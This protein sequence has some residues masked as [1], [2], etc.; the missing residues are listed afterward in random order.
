MEDSNTKAGQG[1]KAEPFSTNP[2]AQAH[3]QLAACPHIKSLRTW[4]CFVLQCSLGRRKSCATHWLVAVG[5]TSLL[6]FFRETTASPSLLERHLRLYCFR[7]V[8]VRN[9]PLIREKLWLAA[10]VDGPP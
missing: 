9:R 4:L 8:Y 7:F 6:A 10:M 1:T 2:A 5:T 3:W